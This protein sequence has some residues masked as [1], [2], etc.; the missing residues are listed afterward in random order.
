M[1]SESE[2]HSQLYAVNKA[3]SKQSDEFDLIDHS[4][5]ILTDMRRQIYAHVGRFLSSPSRILELNAGTGI[6]AI[7]F[8][9]QGHS[10]HATDLS[11]G[12]VRQ[13]RMKIRARNLEDRLTCQQLSFDA[14]QELDVSA[15]KFDFVFSNFGG[16]NCIPDLTKVTRNLPSL[17]KKGAYVT[18]V[19]MPT[20]CLWEIAAILKGNFRHAFRRFAKNGVNSHLAG[21][22][23]HTY[24]HSLNDI[25]NAFGE[26]FEFIG[27][28]GLAAVSPQPHHDRLVRA[29]PRF[30][31]LTRWLDG[32]LRSYFPFNRWADHLIVTFKYRGRK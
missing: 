2:I 22:Y 25:R 15:F 23:F 3:F 32:G 21:E 20:V 26:D 27:S 7:H 31:R 16:L 12:M 13:I 10:V 4:N 5:P 18:W 8:V 17:L 9:A 28:Q 14:L 24:Y 1:T 30:Y 29:F 6:D 11:D 19:I